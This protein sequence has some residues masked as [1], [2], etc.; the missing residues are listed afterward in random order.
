MLESAISRRRIRRRAAVVIPVCVSFVLVSC[1]DGSPR[2]AD[3]AAASDQPRGPLFADVEQLTPASLPDGWRRCSGGPATLEGAG[4]EWW[5]QT[6]G[7]VV[8]GA[9]SP[10][11]TVTQM[12]PDDEFSAPSATLDGKL[13]RW[14]VLQWT[15]PGSGS[16]YLFTWAFEQNLVIESCC[17]TAAGE[18][19]EAVGK[20]ALVGLRQ[21][22]PP[23]C[24]APESDLS[25]EDLITNLSGW[26]SRLYDVDGCPVRLDIAGMQTFPDDDHCFP[27]V[28]AVTI[29]TPL[30]ASTSGSAPR[31][32]YRDPDGLLYDETLTSRLDLDADRPATAIDTGYRQGDRALWF[33]EADD[34]FVYVV[35]GDRTEAWPRRNDPVY[36]A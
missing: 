29:G 1:G 3:P 19:L 31:S 28:R 22:T 7:P 27:G 17:D 6:F 5:S 35:D 4:S 30:G 16:R 15:D 32:Y 36:C 34:G 25:R 14:D 2:D 23:G 18:H 21:R 8:D 24:T 13:G 10:R 11:I 9:C 20:Q 33:D 12:P 26:Q